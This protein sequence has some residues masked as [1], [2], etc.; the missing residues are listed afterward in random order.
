MSSQPLFQ[1]P[2]LPP[3]P[4]TPADGLPANW[5]FKQPPVEPGTT[6]D[7]YTDA[8]RKV[9]CPEPAVKYVTVKSDDFPTG[10]RTALCD[11]H[12]REHAAKH[13]ARRLG[14]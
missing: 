14:E 10:I 13:A 8:R 2:V 9:T 6:C 12:L 4:P 11:T 3:G 5:R 7:A 1:E